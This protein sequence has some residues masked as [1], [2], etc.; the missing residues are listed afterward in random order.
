MLILVISKCRNEKDADLLRG[1]CLLHGRP[2]L[3]SLGHK[4]LWALVVIQLGIDES[5]RFAT[6]GHFAGVQ[7]VRRYTECLV[8]DQQLF[9]E[10]FDFIQ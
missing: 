6:Q 5:I 10:R 1:G 8:Q 3:K 7:V 4:P 2:G 9:V